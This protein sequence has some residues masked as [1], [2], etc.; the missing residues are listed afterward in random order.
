MKKR[1]VF[2]F[3]T[4]VIIVLFNASFTSDDWVMFKKGNYSILF[5]GNPATDSSIKNTQIGDL[6]IVNHIYETPENIPDSNLV[7]GLSLT[8]YPP[9]YI[10]QDSKTFIKGFF[11]SVVKGAVNGVK[12]KLIEEKDFSL[13]NYP[14]K[15]LKID[16]DNG[17]AIITMKIMLVK[18]RVYALQTIALPGQEVNA[19]AARFFNSFD[20]Q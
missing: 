12:G 5:P 9:K 13:K 16:Y 7:Y 6:T 18:E 10:L 11:D 17:T 1:N 8:D 4:L 2:H 19:N 20:F 14:G 15:E 3:T